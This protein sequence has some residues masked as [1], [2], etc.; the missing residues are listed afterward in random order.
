MEQS[1][2][3][4]IGLSG[5]FLFLCFKTNTRVWILKPRA[6]HHKGD[7]PL[8]KHLST[9]ASVESGAAQLLGVTLSVHHS[10]KEED[11]DMAIGPLY[12][13]MLFSGGRKGKHGFP[14]SLLKY[15]WAQ[16]QYTAEPLGYLSRFI[17]THNRTYL[18][19]TII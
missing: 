10:Y 7:G 2:S 17:Q 3:E 12:K 13:G 18:Q 19:K 5:R 6:G 9:S 15:T 16:L 1:R 11:L 14:K 4:P 8:E